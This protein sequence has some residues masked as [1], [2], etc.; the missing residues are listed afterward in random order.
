MAADHIKRYL[1]DKIQCTGSHPFLFVGSGFSQR[2]MKTERWGELLRYFC[3]EFSGDEFRYNAY[4]SRTNEREYYGQQPEI[5]SLLEVD[6]NKAVFSDSQYRDFLQAH[7]EAIK[8]NISPLKIAVSD[9]LSKA[10]FDA[11]NEEIRFLKKLAVRSVAGI[12]TTN[13]DTLLEHIFTGYRTYVGQEDLIFAQL[14]GL[15]EI[16]KIHGSVDRPDSLVLTSR[17][18]REFEH[19]SAYLIAKLLTIFLEYPIIF[20][21]YSLSD[22]NV[23]NILRQIAVC[24]S[25]SKLDVLQDR[26]IFVDYDDSNTISTRSFQFDN[27]KSISMT[28]IATKDFMPIYEAI[29]EVK[30]R[31]SPRL[32]RQLRRDIYDMVREDTPANKI[33][34][35]DFEQLD[36]LPADASYVLGVATANNG[37]IIKAE[38][39]YADSVLGNK[40]YNNERVVEEYLPELLKAN[41]GG[42]P[43]YKYLVGYDKPV[44]DRVKQSL[45]AHNCIDDFLNDGLRHT[46]PGYRESLQDISVAGI[47]KE[48][49]FEVAYKRLIFLEPS[50]INLDQLKDYLCSIL[51]TEKSPEAVLRNN[52]ELKRLIRIYD[53]VKYHRKMS[54]AT[55]SNSANT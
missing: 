40:Y 35:A 50:E 31:Y 18:Y 48:A 43:M 54:L 45:L 19:L 1:R 29:Y 8:A 2:Y 10:V 36:E 12:I 47:I 6:Y 30:S 34:A 17:D 16:Y 49:G 24:L 27:G 42:L 28:Q 15:G 3:K 7:A 37:G 21:G 23:Q 13:Y 22:R 53:F 20:I 55:S 41:P 46:K 32:L 38:N 25:Q 44:Y 33:V 9:H 4:A 39:L 26:L 11:D 5:A 14:A 51:K 52:S